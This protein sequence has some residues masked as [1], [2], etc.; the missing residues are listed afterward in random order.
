MQLSTNRVNFTNSSVSQF[1]Y[2]KFLSKFRSS[3]KDVH[4]LN[5]ILGLHSAVDISDYDIISDVNVLLEPK[6]KRAIWQNKNSKSLVPFVSRKKLKF[7][8]EKYCQWYK[9]V[10]LFVKNEDFVVEISCDLKTRTM[11]LYT[12][13]KGYILHYKESK[14]SRS[15]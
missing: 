2:V 4:D 11:K 10:I 7:Y 12:S 6:Y 5:T 13:A 1:N 8:G 15:H 3:H 9:C 14:L